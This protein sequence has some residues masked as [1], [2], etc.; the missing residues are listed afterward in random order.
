MG[1]QA[2]V[3]TGEISFTTGV[4]SLYI[5]NLPQAAGDAIRDTIGTAIRKGGLSLPK[6]SVT[7]NRPDRD[8]R[9][10]AP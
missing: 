2:T 9:Q 5:T 6:C 1:L 8:A 4:P 3:A 10:P 7:A